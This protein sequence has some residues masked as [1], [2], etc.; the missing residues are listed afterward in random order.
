MDSEVLNSEEVAQT[1][2]PLSIARGNIHSEN[3]YDSTAEQEAFA[4]HNLDENTLNKFKRALPK[5]QNVRNHG[6][7]GR[8]KFKSQNR[9]GRR[10][11]YIHPK[12]QFV[13]EWSSK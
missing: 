12:Y 5:I 10:Q 8:V 4:Q 9:P 6:F 13:P 3:T 7:A 2:S 11:E 1:I